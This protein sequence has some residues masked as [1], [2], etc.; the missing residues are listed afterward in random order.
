[1][2]AQ[3]PNYRQKQGGTVYKCSKPVSVAAR[4]WRPRRAR[5]F[6]P[7]GGQFNGKLYSFVH[8]VGR[9]APRQPLTI[10]LATQWAMR[11]PSLLVATDNAIV[12]YAVGGHCLARDNERVGYSAARLGAE[13]GLPDSCH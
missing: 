8:F 7:L 4:E 1:M 9:A 11:R 12:P 2:R 3:Q 6:P 5:H 10:K 13:A